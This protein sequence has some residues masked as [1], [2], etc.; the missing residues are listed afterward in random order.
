MD[1][2]MTHYYLAID[3]GGTSCRMRLV[4]DTGRVLGESQSGSANLYL[5]KAV[6]LPHIKQCLENILQQSGLSPHIYPHTYVVAGMAGTECPTPYTWLYE[7]FGDFGDFT[8]VSDCEVSCIGAF[9]GEDGALLISGTGCI[10]WAISNHKN[11]RIGGWGFRI[12]DKYSGAWIGHQA[13]HYTLD[14]YDGLYNSSLCDAILQRFDNAPN[15]IVEWASTATPADY[16]AFAPMVVEYADK[17]DT[18]A[19]DI[20]HRSGCGI[21]HMAAHLLQ[22][23]GCAKWAF[24]GGMSTALTAYLPTEIK[25]KMCPV[26]GD[27]LDGALLLAKRS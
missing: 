20:M 14:T 16:G 1:K 21:G 25:E 18:I 17:G 11:Y 9:S 6:V 4:A 23:S 5:G 27:A 22:T 10:G 24:A 3:G 13:L 12:S 7:Y 19:C 15:T 26:T 8:C 2:D